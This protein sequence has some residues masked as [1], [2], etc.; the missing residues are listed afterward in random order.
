MGFAS[1]VK[2]QV[3]LGDET[4]N[5][6]MLSWHSLEKASQARQLAQ[7]ADL[8]ALGGDLMKALRS[9]GIADA[10]AEAAKSLAAKRATPEGRKKERYEKY[11][12]EEVLVA[13]VETWTL[14]KPV[15]RESIKDLD[16]ET[17]AALHREILDL[18]LPPMDADDAEGKAEGG[19]GASI[20][21]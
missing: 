17:A 16:P 13:S 4:F 2:K 12:R 1:S 7:I 8:R 14:P 21:S 20:N 5:I 18:S 9:D 3:I 6:R 19:T 15:S 10:A 11:D